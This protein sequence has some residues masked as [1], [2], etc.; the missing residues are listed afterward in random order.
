[1]ARAHALL[2][3][4]FPYLKTLGMRR[5]TSNP[6]DLALGKEGRIYVLSRSE[7]A[8]EIRRI[9]W[10]DEN[11]GTIG[12][13]GTE[14]GKFRWPVC[15]VVDED[16]QLYV[17][18]EAL[19]RIS[20]F[21]KEG[22]FLSKWGEA[23]SG[24]GQFNRPAGMAFNP[25]G[26]LHVVDSLNHRVQLFTRDGKFLST[27]GTQ[28]AE[29]GELNLPMGIATDDEGDVYVADWGNHRIQKFSAGG[30]L[31][32]VVGSEGS[33]RGQFMRPT[34]VA[35]DRH[36]DIY[37]ADWG[38]NRVQLFNPDGQY[39]DQF[40]GDATLSTMARTYVRANPRPLRLREM[41]CLEPQKRFH[42]PVSIE[43]DDECRMYVADC[44]P[45]RIQVYQ[46]EVD[47][48]GPEDIVAMPSAPSLSTT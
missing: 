30:A 1:M 38:N 8:T 5:V 19:N 34:G 24:D 13:P 21:N 2:R 4:G 27:W 6:V 9:S 44:G 35:V 39:V 33:E 46:K 25:E 29:P 47:V 16:E 14:D 48:L 41:A 22:D 3:A 31:Q 7:L 43:V 26:H 36:G 20:V 11:L 32:L 28:G 10:D 17:S 15:V 18:D 23:G 40:I 42:G 12:G 45:H 37:V